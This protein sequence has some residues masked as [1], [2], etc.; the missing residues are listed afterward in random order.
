MYT[1]SILKFIADICFL[2]L[3]FSACSQEPRNTP[4]I[5][6]SPEQLKCTSLDIEVLNAPW[7]K[8]S[9]KQL[10]HRLQIIGQNG[11][12]KFYNLGIDRSPDFFFKLIPKVF[13]EFVFIRGASR[14]YAYD[15][16][17]GVLQ[18]LDISL[19]ADFEGQDAQSGLI[20]SVEIS[21]NKL[22]IIGITDH[23]PI[24]LT[25]TDNRRFIRQ[26]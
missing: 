1:G 10:D 2:A 13:N 16:H 26:K 23:K 22:L 4:V 24:Q 15:C 6:Y 21:E 3:L 17:S 19:D 18:E 8:E 20:N 7:A 25:L 11:E 9:S 5:T 12:Y 14:V